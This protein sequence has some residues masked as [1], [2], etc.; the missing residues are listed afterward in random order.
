MP[1]TRFCR[2]AVKKA[3]FILLL[4]INLH[5]MSA[6]S[7][8]ADFAVTSPW[9]GAIASFIGGDKVH[10]RYLSVWNDKGMVASVGRPRSSEIVIALDADDAAGLAWDGAAGGAGAGEVTAA[11]RGGFGGHPVTSRVLTRV[12][13][14]AMVVS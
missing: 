13:T 5:A 1:Y 9:V 11:P 7:H 12:S 10:V 6:V 14:L 2:F 4:I 8:A 3:V